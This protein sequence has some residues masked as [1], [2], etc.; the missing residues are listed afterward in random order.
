M[1]PGGWAGPAVPLPARRACQ[2]PGCGS[3]CRPRAAVAGGRTSGR[4]GERRCPVSR[5]CHFR[6]RIIDINFPCDGRPAWTSAMADGDGGACNTRA[7]GG[8]GPVRLACP[9]CGCRRNPDREGL[10]Q[11]HGHGSLYPVMPAAMSTARSPAPIADAMPSDPGMRSLRQR[12]VQALRYRPERGD[13]GRRTR[14]RVVVT[15]QDAGAPLDPLDPLDP[16]SHSYACVRGSAQAPG[17]GL[18]VAVRA[19]RCRRQASGRTGA[20]GRRGG[21]TTARVKGHHGKS[22]GRGPAGPTSPSFRCARGHRIQSRPHDGG[23]GLPMVVTAGLASACPRGGHRRMAGQ[24]V[25]AAGS[26][27]HR[28]CNAGLDMVYKCTP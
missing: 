7:P 1:K 28:L 5:G 8:L 6:V 21:A 12:H 16:H 2:T 20:H 25:H 10:G 23:V 26:G 9:A 27:A 17:T 13:A 15:G 14:S 19:G 11:A 22:G 18:Q 3:P 4:T 24:P